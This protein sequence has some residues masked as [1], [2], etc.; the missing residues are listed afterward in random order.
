MESN[1][2]LLFVVNMQMF[3]L[4]YYDPCDIVSEQAA[5]ED[6]QVEKCY[7][8]SEGQ[9]LGLEEVRSEMGSLET[10]QIA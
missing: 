2:S 10:D 8:I 3:E 5:I 9:S 4:G 7:L 1:I 6:F